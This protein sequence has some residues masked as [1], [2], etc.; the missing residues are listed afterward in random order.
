MREL[1]SDILKASK[2]D[3]KLLVGRLR[4]RCTAIDYIKPAALA[5]PLTAYQYR[6]NAAAKL[7]RLGAAA[8]TPQ[9]V[10]S[11]ADLAPALSTA[12]FKH[13]LPTRAVYFGGQVV[14]LAIGKAHAFVDNFSHFSSF[15]HPSYVSSEGA[16]EPLNLFAQG[17][18]LAV[19][20]A[21][22]CV[23]NGKIA[24]KLTA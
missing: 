16:V 24:C 9:A 2:A 13:K 18:H 1:F 19:N 22:R 10:Y 4:Q 6:G 8:A 3:G 14:L 17:A 7:V 20:A 5:S 12:K 21:E 15:R 11:V 23:C